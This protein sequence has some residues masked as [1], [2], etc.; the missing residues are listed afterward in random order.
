MK[1]IL[2]SVMYGGAYPFEDLAENV[3]PVRSP[4]QMVERDAIL[5]VWGGADI[6]PALYGHKPSKT[7]YTS[8]TR[9]AVEW[10]C[11]KRAV[12]MGIPIIG[13]C[14]GAQMLCALAGGFLLQDVE[15]HAG[16][17]HTASTIDGSVIHV[18]SIHHQMMAGLEGVEHE[19]LAWCD[20]PRSPTY[21]WKDDLIYTPPAGFKEPEMVWFPK[22]KGM[23]IQWHPEAMAKECDASP[24][25]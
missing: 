12:E 19:L 18:N 1:K 10:P 22:V 6:S 16:P 5:V 14:R 13:V 3:V 24:F 11:M 21:T 2:Y 7:I 20:V 8:P 25:A 9:D 4:D 23:A 15:N 17:R